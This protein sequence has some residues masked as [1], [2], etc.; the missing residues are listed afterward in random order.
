MNH[1]ATNLFTREKLCEKLEIL[2]KSNI[3]NDEIVKP[4]LWVSYKDHAL[5]KCLLMKK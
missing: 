2:K 1:G 3:S 5:Y 4:T